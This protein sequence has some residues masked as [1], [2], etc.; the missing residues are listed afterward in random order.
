LLKAYYK[1]QRGISLGAK[2][3]KKMVQYLFQGLMGIG[4]I[5][6]FAVAYGAIVDPTSWTDTA[7]GEHVSS[8]EGYFIGLAFAAGGLLFAGFTYIAPRMPITFNGTL[9]EDEKPTGLAW[10]MN[11]TGLNNRSWAGA[12]I[13]WS[14]FDRAEK[15]VD[16]SGAA[17]LTF[18]FTGKPAVEQYVGEQEANQWNEGVGYVLDIA[19]TSASMPKTKAAL[20]EFCPRLVE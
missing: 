6:F 15:D 14:A 10:Q 2:I 7:T 5:M 11:A 8:T 12:V 1:E 13:P 20:M 17:C 16:P 4:A 9:P 18:Y 3:N 19:R